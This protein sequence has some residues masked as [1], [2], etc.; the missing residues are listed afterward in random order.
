MHAYKT[1]THNTYIHKN[2]YI[3]I[4]LNKKALS[5]AVVVLAFNASIQESKSEFE[6]SLVYRVL[7]QPR[8]HTQR[9]PVSKKTKKPNQNKPQTNPSLSNG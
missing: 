8:I 4:F 9:N 3:K 5:W 2:K 6:A 7:G 1:H